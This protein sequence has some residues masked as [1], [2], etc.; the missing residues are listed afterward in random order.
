VI[1][2]DTGFSRFL[3][4][5]EGLFCFETCD[6]VIEAIDTMNS[7]YAGHSRAARTIAEEY[8]DSDKVLSELLKQ[9]GVDL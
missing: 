9:I 1:A 3:P 7:D 8:F 6:D 2:Q 5:G 4:V